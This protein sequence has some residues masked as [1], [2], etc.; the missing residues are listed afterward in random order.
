MASSS[1]APM[2]KQPPSTPPLTREQITEMGI[3]GPKIYKTEEEKTKGKEK[4]LEE[5]SNKEKGKLMKFLLTAKKFLNDPDLQTGHHT[6]GR[7]EIEKAVKE[8]QEW[9]NQ[10]HDRAT[11]VEFTEQLEE[12]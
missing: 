11:S 2:V 9:F 12:D 8:A 10:N 3:F 7:E 6:V 5:I 1:D 4:E